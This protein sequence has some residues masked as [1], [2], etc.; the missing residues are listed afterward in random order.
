LDVEAISGVFAGLRE[1]GLP[2]PGEIGV[3]GELLALVVG[4]S[5]TAHVPDEGL[6]ADEDAVEVVTIAIA[7]AITV[8]VAVT[9]AVTIA[10]AVAVAVAI[11]IAIAV[12]VAVATGILI[13]G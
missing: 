8:A 2:S 3:V 6:G 10:V 7:V 4:E 1:D 11:A 9:I 13:P 5:E 12:A